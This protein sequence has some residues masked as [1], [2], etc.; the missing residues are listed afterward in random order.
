MSVIG[1]TQ[2]ILLLTMHVAFFLLLDRRKPHSAKF[3]Q[4]TSVLVVVIKVVVFGLSFFLLQASADNLPSNMQ[5]VISYVILALQML[6][7]FCLLAR[8]LYIFWQTRKIKN[9]K[10]D[11]RRRPH[12]VTP[13]HLRMH[14]FESMRGSVK[15][16]Q[17]EW[18]SEFYNDHQPPLKQTSL[19]EIRQTGRHGAHGGKRSTDHD[20]NEYAI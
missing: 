11:E 19:R 1:K 10:D 4:N 2:L 9:E 15:Q 7:L 14:A 8:Q 16:H 12:D 17:R 18:T 6:V 3:V 13:P 5:Q 20:P